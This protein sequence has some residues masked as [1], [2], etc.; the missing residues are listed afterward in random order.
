MSQLPTIPWPQTPRCILREL[1]PEDLQTATQILSENLVFFEQIQSP[2]SP[3][4]LADE[5]VYHRS[6]P[7]HGH[8]KYSHCA[9]ISDRESLESRGI[10]SIYRGYPD[11]ASIYLGDFYL[12]P[13]W[14]RLGLGQEVATAI[15]AQTRAAG[16][17]KIVLA[18]NATNWSGLHFWVAQGYRSITKVVGH[19]E[20]DGPFKARI[21]L[22]KDLLASSH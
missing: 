21:E 15:E 5:I 4:D 1:H 9:L 8:R 14:H 11:D 19:L 17:R 18:V 7:P 20:K 12:R 16:F 2:D 13:A 6:L 3:A 22:C 10:L